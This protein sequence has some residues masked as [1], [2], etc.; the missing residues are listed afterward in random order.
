MNGYTG[1]MGRWMNRGTGPVKPGYFLTQERAGSGVVDL[2][3][4]AGGRVGVCTAVRAL[5]YT[6]VC[7]RRWNRVGACARAR[8]RGG[9][10]PSCLAQH[11]DG[12]PVSTSAPARKCVLVTGNGVS[13]CSGALP[14]MARR[15]RC[16]QGR[17]WLSDQPEPGLPSPRGGRRL[18]SQRVCQQSQRWGRRRLIHGVGLR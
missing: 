17:P 16:G 15:Q 6:C 7:A 18:V 2:C 14:D 10:D 13:L 5:V 3:Q 12:P 11:R 8:A 1:G 9:S 4:R